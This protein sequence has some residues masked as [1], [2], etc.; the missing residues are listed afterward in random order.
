M[1]Q[2]ETLNKPIQTKPR[3]NEPKGDLK[4]ART[5]QIEPKETLNEPKQSETTQN[6]HQ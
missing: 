1:S 6:Q 4:Q 5:T 2:K 3:Q